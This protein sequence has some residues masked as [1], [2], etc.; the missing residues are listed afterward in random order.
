MKTKA[1][2]MPEIISISTLVEVLADK[3][4][5]T[6]IDQLFT[7]YRCYCKVLREK[8]KAIPTFDSFYGWG[9]TAISDFNEVDMAGVDPEEI[10]K[11]LNDFKE[12]STNFLTDD[13]LDVMEKY[14]GFS[15]LAGNVEEFWKKTDEKSGLSGKF[16]ELWRILG[17]L[18][19]SFHESLSARGLTTTGGM[20]RE[21]AE[22]VAGGDDTESVLPDV[23]KIIFIGFNALSVSEFRIFRG[24][25]RLRKYEGPYGA[26]PFADFVWDGTGP[27]LTSDDSPAG[28]FLR[29]N[30]KNF[31]EPEWIEKYVAESDTES[32]PESMRVISSPS[33]VAQ[34]K[35]VSDELA[36][37]KERIES[38]SF[39]NA[40]V[41]VILPDE[42]LLLPM[43]YSFPADIGDVNLTMG[44]SL[45]LT[46]VVSFI[47]LLRRLQATSWISGEEVRY[48]APDLRLML[49]HPFCR[50]VVG[51]E[52]CDAI[53]D[54]LNKY[55]R[56]SM[57]ISEINRISDLASGLLAPLGDRRSPGE[58]I[59][60]IDNAL[61][62]VEVSLSAGLRA[63]LKE[64]LD[65]SHIEVCRRALKNLEEALM[66]YDIE[67]NPSTLFMLADRM[68]SNVKVHFEGEPLNGLQVMGLLETR[69]LDFDYLFILSVNEGVIPRRQRHRSFLPNTLRSGYGMPPANYQETLFSYYFYRMIS[70]AK[71]VVMI[72]DGRSG[73]YK[74][75]DVSRYVLQLRYLYATDSLKHEERNF[76][77]YT[78]NAE[79]PDI[80]KTEAVM[81]F[82]SQYY[83]D[84]GGKK[85]ISAS[86]FQ[87]YLHCPVKFFLKRI[88]GIPE[89]KD[90]SGFID[91][92]TQGLIVHRV[93]EWCYV[94]PRESGKFLSPPKRITT[95]FLQKLISDRAYLMKLMVRAINEQHFLK[96][97]SELDSPLTKDAEIIAS[98]LVNQVVNVLKYDL[99]FT[100]FDLYGCEIREDTKVELPGLP[101]FNT[102]C[103]IDRVDKVRIDG[104][105]VIR[106]IDYKTGKARLT[107]D[108]FEDIFAGVDKSKHIFQLQFYANLMEGLLVPEGTDIRTEIYEVERIGR[109]EVRIP[110]I[111]DEEDREVP[112][113]SH[114]E[115]ESCFKE[116][117][118]AKLKELTDPATPFTRCRPD[119]CGYCD[120]KSL[121][122]R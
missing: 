20:Y 94:T 22:R 8:G 28:E 36:S 16:L 80:E 110:V 117:F 2:I 25:K 111:K 112:V 11:N 56:N 70:R 44:Y 19:K 97:G 81:E 75:G 104:R 14:F 88:V 4:E 18:Y 52:G 83:A 89:E 63:E 86:M 23:S 50:A 5:D 122:R 35:I 21:A 49:A 114:R 109:Q 82:L 54:Y 92:M 29:R 3:I 58:V 13:Q 116:S 95:E 1:C 118:S 59:Q 99:Q 69:A 103:V 108:K 46:S 33:N 51:S 26:E 78:N 113:S 79:A 77:I 121:C 41:A 96:K 90:T 15:P 37:L 119:D 53:V 60:F 9:E 10:F 101:A 87:D 72:Y 55:H 85:K 45:K 57:S 71:E 43:L 98:I 47:H 76:K 66:E 67:M 64:S 6:K 73:T 102:V 107:A 105:E 24:L 31:P 42:N 27:V 62:C 40:N 30:R 106:V 61:D 38:A 34:V 91:I 115:I 74:T 7:L 65:K 68:I 17:G 12:I 84:K 100:P 93:L 48:Y 39:E 32:L 120:F